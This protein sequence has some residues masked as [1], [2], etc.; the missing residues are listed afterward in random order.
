[1]FEHVYAIFFAHFKNIFDINIV[2][3]LQFDKTKFKPR[4]KLTISINLVLIKLKC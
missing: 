1:M 2:V 3:T 4:L